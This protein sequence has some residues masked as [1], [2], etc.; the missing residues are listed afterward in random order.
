MNRT[1]KEVARYRYSALARA[2]PVRTDLHLTRK[3]WHM[4][5]GL[6]IISLYMSG[7]PQSTALTILG[8]LLGWSAVMETLRLKNPGINEKCIRFFGPVI[9]SCE[10]N[11]VSGM[12]YYIASAFV[13]IAVFPKP[14]A[15][16]S[17]AF[18]ALGDPLASLVGIL[19][20]QRSVKIFNG[21]KSLHGTAAGYFVCAATTWLYLKSTGMVGLDL[22]RLSLLGGFAGAFA[23]L[24]PLEIDD[25]FTIP[26]IS[27]FIMWLGFIAVHFIS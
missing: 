20:S 22:I 3:I 21:A 16:L 7:M 8:L 17:I 6:L 11:R 13:A 19:Y 15:I 24:L 5:T 18:L 4:M 2:L 27:G 23:E 26:V 25:N 1:I 10:V 9:R 12:P 14:V